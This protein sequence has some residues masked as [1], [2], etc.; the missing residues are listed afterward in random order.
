MT[1]LEE[2]GMTLLEAAKALLTAWDDEEEYGVFGPAMEALR[3][4][5]EAAETVRPG[6]IELASV[7][8]RTVQQWPFEA[9]HTVVQ[10][11]YQTLFI[12]EARTA[13][14]QPGLNVAERLLDHQVTLIFNVDQ[15]AKTGVL[16]R[17][18]SHPTV[19]PAYLVLD[20]DDDI[21]YPL[22]SIQDIRE[23]S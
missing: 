11:A 1:A 5:I 4:A 17:I 13:L 10:P 12:D 2:E 23:V 6:G 14:G 9:S 21:L 7:P 8:M 18:I 20:N 19:G 16:T 3:L 22:N 15:P